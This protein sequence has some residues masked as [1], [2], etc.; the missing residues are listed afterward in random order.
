MRA[1][2]L[3]PVRCAQA[4]WTRPF[5]PAST[6][7]AIDGNA[8]VRNR[9]PDIAWSKGTIVATVEVFFEGKLA[10]KSSERATKIESGLLDV[11]NC[12]HAA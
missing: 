3:A 7:V 5:P 2:W 12:R 11:A 6:D 8:F 1:S 9:V 4:T 10:P